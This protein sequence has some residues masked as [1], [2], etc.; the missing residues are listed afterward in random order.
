MRRIALLLPVVL[1]L[2]SLG[3][4]SAEARRKKKLPPVV[5]TPDGD[6]V[7]LH[8]E[9]NESAQGWLN[10]TPLEE[11]DAEEKGPLPGLFVALHGAGGKPKNFLM[12]GLM[13]SREAWCLALAGRE[14]VQTVHG[15]GV[16]WSGGDV[17]TIAALSR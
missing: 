8:I 4:P 5:E 3:A 11:G 7:R 17:E 13:A 1:L 10:K 9:G 15:Q 16:W 12:R 2:T 14:A 6:L